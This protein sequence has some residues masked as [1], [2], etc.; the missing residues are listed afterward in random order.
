[1]VKLGSRK[2][3]VLNENFETLAL[4]DFFEILKQKTKLELVQINLNVNVTKKDFRTKCFTNLLSTLE[5]L[6][7]VK[8]KCVIFE[9]HPSEVAMV[10]PC[11]G[12]LELIE[13]FSTQARYKLDELIYLEQ[14]KM[15]KRF[16]GVSYCDAFSI[17]VESLLHFEHFDIHLS[18]FTVE[19][20][21]KMR[22][23][24]LESKHV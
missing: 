21:L 20:C 18:T 5:T 10:L 13:I 12:E 1:M 8:A 19:D 6:K 2:C 3:T 4:K 7:P 14:W 9:L 15:A 22:N 23:A 17:P 24:S 11:F 16:K